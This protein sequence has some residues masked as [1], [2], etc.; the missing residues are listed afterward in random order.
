MNTLRIQ[1]ILEKDGEVCFSNLPFRKGDRV[2][3]IFTLLSKN[4]DE[5][6][7]EALISFIERAKQSKFRSLGP[8][9]SRDELHER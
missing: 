6:R 4:D 9:P 2:E 8:Y 3:A 1:T 5:M 7:S